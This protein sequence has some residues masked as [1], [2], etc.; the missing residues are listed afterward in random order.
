[1]KN[2]L[3]AVGF[4]ICMFFSVAAFAQAAQSPAPAKEAPS[5]NAAV[6]QK[7]YSGNKRNHVFH[8][9]GCRYYNCKTCTERFDTVEEAQKAGYAPCKI[10]MKTSQPSKN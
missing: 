8:K 7:A 4:C 2:V 10:C 6:V 5:D 3:L 9:L 1:M